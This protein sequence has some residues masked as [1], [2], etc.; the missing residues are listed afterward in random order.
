MDIMPIKIVILGAIPEAILM[1]WAGLLLMR[2][3]PQLRQVIIIGILQG[4]T[5][6]FIRQYVD[7]G[8]HT[9]AILC[10]LIVYTCLIMKVK[11]IVGS[12]AILVSCIIVTLIEGSLFIFIDVNLIHLLSKNGMRL[13]FLLPHEGVL[14]FI[15][16]IGHK[17]DISLLNEFTWLKKIT[18]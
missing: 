11:W 7:F 5:T 3:K 2:V 6:Y 18:Q 14:A 16:Y 12:I 15:V 10:T 17:K 8:V 13:L 1:V 9:F 4:V